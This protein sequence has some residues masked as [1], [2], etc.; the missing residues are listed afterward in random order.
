MEFL[1]HC[2]TKNQ[3]YFNFSIPDKEYYTT[4]L[5]AI[6]CCAHL[7]GEFVEYNENN[8]IASVV[9]MLSIPHN[10]EY[11]CIV[12]NILN[13]KQLLDF[14]FAA[15]SIH[16][17]YEQIKNKKICFLY[18]ASFNLEFLNS[19]ID[20]LVDGCIIVSDFVLD[21]NNDKLYVE[22]IFDKTYQINYL[23]RNIVIKNNF[24]PKRWAITN[25]HWGDMIFNLLDIRHRLGNS[26]GII[27]ETTD[28]NLLNFVYQHDF[29][30]K[31]YYLSDKTKNF[32]DYETKEKI[33]LKTIKY[34]NSMKLLECRIMKRVADQYAIVSWDD[35]TLKI[36]KEAQNYI[37]NLKKYFNNEEYILIQPYSATKDGVWEHWDK[38]MD[39]IFLD[40]TKNYIICGTKWND[41]RYKNKSN[42]LNL[43]GKTPTAVHVFA[44]TELVKKTITTCNSLGC[45]C[46][47][48]RKS[49]R[50]FG[51]TVNFVDM[52]YSVFFKSVGGDT[53][54]IDIYM[55]FVAALYSINQYLSLDLEII[56]NS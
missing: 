30:K 41:K 16:S 1:N 51:N 28:D 4:I 12:P 45:W 37:S 13:S 24:L 2:L 55:P 50:I 9:P 43:M 18:L 39:F 53:W 6:C 11:N 36:T 38:L 32:I 26:C 14:N 3:E 15:L 21:I 44:I 10:K 46:I 8:F 27:I 29:V 34:I 23:K 33:D 48:H 35:K 5:S 40:T 49:S 56:K 19:I 7:E 54:L 25:G 31:L 17:S 20:Q 47:V 22:K 52:W 42:I